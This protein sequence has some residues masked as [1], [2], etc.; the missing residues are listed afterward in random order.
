MTELASRHA[1]SRAV[2][3]Q[4]LR[5]RRHER[6]AHR[7]FGE[8]VAD[9]GWE[10]GTRRGTR[11][12]RRRRRSR[13]AST[14][15]RTRPED[16]A[17]HGRQAEDPGG[18]G[19]ARRR[20]RRMQSR[21]HSVACR[22]LCDGG[23]CPSTN[24]RT[25]SVNA[26][27]KGLRPCGGSPKED[28]ERLTRPFKVYRRCGRGEM[29][30]RGSDA[31]KSRG[32]ERVRAQPSAARTAS[33]TFL[34]STVFPASSPSPPSSPCPCPWAWWRRSRRPPRRRRAAISSSVA[35]GGR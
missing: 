29:F 14:C 2:G 26:A 21:C 19:Q 30:D 20:R 33:L 16:A 34:P 12:S 1:R 6:R 24:I 9:A 13:Y 23:H 27:K 35:A 31:G 17:G 18:A 22:F 10:C 32:D 8:Q 4:L 11:P 3:R 15:S 7:A 25:S 5:E 28:G